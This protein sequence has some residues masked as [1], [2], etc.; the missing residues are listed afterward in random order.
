MR[1]RTN[2]INY[3]Q[4]PVGYTVVT[5]T[6]AASLHFRFR[7]PEVSLGRNGL[8]THPRDKVK[9]M[10]STRKTPRKNQFNMSKIIQILNNKDSYS[11]EFFRRAQ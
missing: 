10:A 7:A 1:G 6:V 3:T 4:I 5:R 11:I 9:E 8:K 2:G